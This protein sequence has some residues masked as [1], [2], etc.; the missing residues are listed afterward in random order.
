MRKVI[1]TLWLQGFDNAPFVIKKCLE[2]WIFWNPTWKIVQLDENNLKE[3]ID[4]DEIIPNI[5]NKTISRPSLSDIIR[6]SLLKKHGGLWIDATLFCMKPLD[7]WLPTYAIK[8]FFGFKLVMRNRR[9]ATWFM[10]SDKDHYLIDKWYIQIQK[11][12]ANRDTKHNYFWVHEQ[13][14]ILYKTDPRFR[15]LFGGIPNFRAGGRGGPLF[16]LRKFLQ[17]LNPNYKSIVDSGRIPFFKLTYKRDFDK[18]TEKCV[19]AYIIK[20]L[21]DAIYKKNKNLPI[22]YNANIS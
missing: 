17:D 10:Y 9:M 6:V 11:Y 4:L 20:Q 7:D 3:Y 8:N 15:R 13:F 22:K 12:W 16:F 14:T 19:A 2:S 5:K 18:Y 21:D 1:Y